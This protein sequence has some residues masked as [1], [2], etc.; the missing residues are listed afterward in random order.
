MRY[1]LIAA[2]LL[3]ALAACETESLPPLVAADVIVTEPVPGHRMSAAYLSLSNNS[4]NAIRINRVSSP[5]FGAVELHE[6]SVEDGVAK[7]RPVEELVIAPNSKVALQ[8]GGLHLMLMR[9]NADIDEVSLN[10]Y[11]D[12]TL[13]L[14]V[15]TKITRRSN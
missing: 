1:L 11:Q 3:L 2:T 15:D 12:T 6:S 13:L 10:F 9:P 8:P 4:R 5:N 14:S 7:M